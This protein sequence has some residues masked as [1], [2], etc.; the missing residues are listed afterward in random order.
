MDT[1]MESFK[2][3]KSEWAKPATSVFPLH[4]QGS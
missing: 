3:K 2:A 1:R 4:T